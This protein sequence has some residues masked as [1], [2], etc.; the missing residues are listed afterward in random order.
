MEVA[1]CVETCK[2]MKGCNQC[3]KCCINYSDGGLSASAE[4]IEFWESYRPE[5]YQYVSGGKIWMDPE[6]GKQLVRCPWLKK[7]P[8]ENKT[9]CEIYGDRP[10]DCTFY[11]VTIDQMV[12]DQCEMLEDRDLVRPKQAQK[13]LNQL[14]ADSRPPYE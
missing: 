11:P 5:I 10:D 7:L 13:A 8:N 3:G 12:K 9:I 4:E 1:S 2:K 14:M 6:T